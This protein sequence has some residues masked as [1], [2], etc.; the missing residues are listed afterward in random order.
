M[1]GLLG[2]E[3]DWRRKWVTRGMPLKNICFPEMLPLSM[4]FLATIRR[5]AQLSSTKPY[6]WDALSHHRL[7][8]TEPSD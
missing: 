2:D 1:N 7:R 8:N 4:R 5:A 6:Y 3:P